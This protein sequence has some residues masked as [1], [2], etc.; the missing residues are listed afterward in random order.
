MCAP[1]PVARSTPPWLPASPV[2]ELCTHQRDTSGTQA[3]RVHAECCAGA[4]WRGDAYSRRHR[5]R[6]RWRAHGQRRQLV[7][8]GVP[9][10]HDAAHQP[11]L[12]PGD[13]AHINFDV[14]GSCVQGITTNGNYTKVIGNR[15]HDMPDSQL[16]AAIVVD[17]CSYTKSGNQV[18]G[19][20]VDNIGPRGQVNQTLTMSTT[21]T[22]STTMRRTCL[23]RSRAP[24]SVP[25][26]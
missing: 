9:L 11:V 7:Q 1:L 12:A 21:T 5:C 13:N 25:S 23:L 14:T 15:A 16:T 3:A 22:S 17:C 26:S 24:S 2:S 19:N 6:S 8:R 20:V 10:L 18:I 4:T